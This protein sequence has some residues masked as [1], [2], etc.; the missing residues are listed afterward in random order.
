VQA[1]TEGIEAYLRTPKG[2][3]RAVADGLSGDGES[4]RPDFSQVWRWVNTF[5]SITKEQLVTRLQRG[6]VKLGKESELQQIWDCAVVEP[7]KA[8]TV[9]KWQALVAAVLVQALAALVFGA[10]E[11]VLVNLHTYFA[12]K[13]KR[14]FS[15]FTGRGGRMLATQ[16]P[17]QVIF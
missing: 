2:T 9:G 13:V 11:N 12:S 15:I 6:A 5:A 14:P 16:S 7:R 17:Q 10:M 3:Y 4:R 8:R 1:V